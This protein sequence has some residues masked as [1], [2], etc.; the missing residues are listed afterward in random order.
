[1][2]ARLAATMTVLTMATQTRLVVARDHH[3]KLRDRLGKDEGASTLEYIVLGLGGFL[4]ATAVIV[5]ITAAIRGR[6][7]QIR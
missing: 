2:T 6:L 3:A 7:T 1:M 4:I 5:G